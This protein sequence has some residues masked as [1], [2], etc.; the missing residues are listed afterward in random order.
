MKNQNFSRIQPDTVD[1]VSPGEQHLIAA[2]GFLQLRMFD[3]AL[4][5]LDLADKE[6]QLRMAVAGIKLDL[7]LA[8]EDW[9][10]AASYGGALADLDPEYSPYTY[11]WAKALHAL[12]RT[13]RAL[14]V[15]EDLDEDYEHDPEFRYESAF[16]SA[17]C[18]QIESAIVHLGQ[19]VAMDSS[20]RQKAAEEPLLRDLLDKILP[21]IEPEPSSSN[22]PFGSDFDPFPTNLAQPF[23]DDESDIPF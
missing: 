7:Y 16:Y 1:R 9:K 2:E 17:A 13:E 20:N 18:G 12:G 4:C 10:T 8:K 6:P 5:E 11:K 14:A 15:I 23:E 21:G 22:D 19:A 3:E